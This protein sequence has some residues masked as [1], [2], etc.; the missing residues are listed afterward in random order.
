MKV[1]HPLRHA[2]LCDAEPNFVVSDYCISVLTYFSF[3]FITI[4]FSSPIYYSIDIYCAKCG[5]FP[6]APQI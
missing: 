5:T 3:T 2:T 1:S 6:S 4:T